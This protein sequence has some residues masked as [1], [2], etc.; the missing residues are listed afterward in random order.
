MDR[1]QYT[2]E[3]IE[4]HKNMKLFRNSIGCD[5]SSS[6]GSLTVNLKLMSALEV[7]T[8]WCVRT[9]TFISAAPKGPAVRVLAPQSLGRWTT[10][11]A[12]GKVFLPIHML[13]IGRV[14]GNFWA[15][16][17]VPSALL[18]AFG[19][20]NNNFSLITHI[21][22]ILNRRLHSF[23]PPSLSP[24]R[25]LN[26]SPNRNWILKAA[27]ASSRY[28]GKTINFI[29]NTPA[30]HIN[31]SW[32][33]SCSNLLLL[34]LLGCLSVLHHTTAYHLCWAATDSV[35]GVSYFWV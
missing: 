16:K 23:L 25:R 10:H 20:R 35:A 30:L 12:K 9:I 34:H 7:F 1:A 13:F 6:W 2:D 5:D 15:C 28:C 32:S 17:C 4:A 8:L 31:C 21:T 33:P 26:I 22:R 14:M 3:P 29:H 18:I 27:A 19:M 24:V 11:S